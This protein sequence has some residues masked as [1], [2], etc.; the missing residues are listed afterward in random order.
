[1]VLKI[2]K[3]TPC[4][5]G[6]QFVQKVKLFKCTHSYLSSKDGLHFTHGRG[7]L[8][9]GNLKVEQMSTNFSRREASHTSPLEPRTLK[10]NRLALT[11]QEEKLLTLLDLGSNYCYRMGII[12]VMVGKP[13]VSFHPWEWNPHIN[14]NPKVA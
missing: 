2:F 10:L 7:T 1:M 9:N 11:F 6:L 12:S 5:Y 13:P 14:G 8:I 3:F 4:L